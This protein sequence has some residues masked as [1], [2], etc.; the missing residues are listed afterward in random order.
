MRRG[1]ETPG[2]TPSSS[3]FIRDCGDGIHFVVVDT[4]GVILIPGNA[5]IL[6][7]YNRNTGNW[8]SGEDYIDFTD[9]YYH[10]NE[11]SIFNLCGT[12]R[13]ADAEGMLRD[14][15]TDDPRWSPDDVPVDWMLYRGETLIVARNLNK[16][17][18]PASLPIWQ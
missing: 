17:I 3:L 4:N 7:G 9:E 11:D 18:S 13:A 15:S 16:L 12:R 6:F 1:G 10:E 8:Y 5:Y 14:F 2:P